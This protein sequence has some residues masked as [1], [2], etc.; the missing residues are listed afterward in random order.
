LISF[1]IFFGSNFFSFV[2]AFGLG[3]G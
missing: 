2:L 1:F 3:K